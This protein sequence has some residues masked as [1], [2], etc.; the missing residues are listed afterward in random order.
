MWFMIVVNQVF[1]RFLVLRHTFCC[2]LV[3]MVTCLVVS[4]R[5]TFHTDAALRL[6]F[7]PSEGDVKSCATVATFGTDN[8]RFTELK[9]M[10]LQCCAVVA[11]FKEPNRR[12]GRAVASATS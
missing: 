1:W 11:P 2:F 5:T 6:L 8:Q 3:L 12:P 7:G 4:T 9:D 10:F